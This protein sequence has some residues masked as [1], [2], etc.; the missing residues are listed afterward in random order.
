MKSRNYLTQWVVFWGLLL[1][2]ATSSCMPQTPYVLDPLGTLPVVAEGNEIN[3]VE[4]DWYK[5][6]FSDPNSPTASSYKGGPDEALAEAIDQARLKIDLAAYDFD[7]WSLRNALIA[8]HKRGVAVRVVVETS[9]LDE[10][11]IQ[12]LIEAG[13]PV[14]DDQNNGLMHNKFVVIDEAHVWLGSMNLTVNGAYKN[15]NNL[16]YV[17]SSRLA[18]NYTQ[19]FEEMF[20]NQLFG[21]NTK[22][23]TPHQ[24]FDLNGTQIETYF[25]PDD[26]TSQ[27]IEELI[28]VASESIYFMAFSFTSDSIADAML[29]RAYE[30]VTVMGVFE[31]AQY[32][33]NTG[34]EFDR[35]Y[36]ADLDVRLDGNPKFMHHKVIIIDESIVITGSYNFSASAEKSNDENTLIIHNSG[37]ALKY[38]TEFERIFAEAQGK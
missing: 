22:I 7:L 12:D 3:A 24:T 23:D 34:T 28:Q 38:M 19:E 27:R 37:L 8:A 25:S 9:N 11:E 5:V 30:G 2:L 4:D 17:R 1:G 26:G 32:Y 13:I 31:E 36:N 14:V 18:E 29:E 16:L 10:D 6:Y 15:N 20:T 21:S 35:F 33:S